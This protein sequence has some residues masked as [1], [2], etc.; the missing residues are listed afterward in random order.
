MKKI[1]K[2]DHYKKEDQKLIVNG[3]SKGQVTA[4]AKHPF[5]EAIV[6]IDGAFIKRME[7]GESFNI[8]EI[9]KG[10]L[11]VTILI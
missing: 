9:E 8:E 1:V 7:Q 10:K 5:T 11:I 2:F 6:P 4:Y 3:V